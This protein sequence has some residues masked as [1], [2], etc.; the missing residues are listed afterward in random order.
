MY[1]LLRLVKVV[2]EY[3]FYR[4]TTTGGDGESELLVLQYDDLLFLS[5][6]VR[7]G[8]WGAPGAVEGGGVSRGLWGSGLLSYDVGGIR[9][10]RCLLS[11][12]G[13][14]EPGEPDEYGPR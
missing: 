9:R 6:L 10:W 14:A 1:G 12:V 11:R 3:S 2:S 5:L 8:G 7:G 13:L 4:S